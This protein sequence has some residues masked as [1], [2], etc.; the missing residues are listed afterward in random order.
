M[1][2]G[3]NPVAPTIEGRSVAR[4]TGEAAAFAFAGSGSRP[5][6][7]P[8][9]MALDAPNASSARPLPSAVPSFLEACARL[10]AEAAARHD[11][12][13]ASELIEK[14]ARVAALQSSSTHET[15]S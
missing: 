14:A 5:T 1:V 12:A 11:F 3:S 15:G 7:A 2:A 4:E 9:G 13:R 8:R 6:G 10:A